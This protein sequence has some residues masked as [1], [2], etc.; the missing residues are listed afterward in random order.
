MGRGGREV[1]EG[2]DIYTDTADLLHCIAETTQYYKA[3]APPCPPLPPPKKTLCSC[4][5]CVGALQYVGKILR[6]LGWPL[7]VPIFRSFTLE[8]R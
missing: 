7:S 4:R 8:I 5:R 3:I 6:A 2:G 1:Q